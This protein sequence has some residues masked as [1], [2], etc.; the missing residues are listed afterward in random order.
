M[1]RL[2]IIT[3]ITVQKNKSDRYNIFMDYG[4]G[5]EYA[6]SLD[7][8]VLIKSH[9]KKGLELDPFSITEITY[10]DDIRKAYNLAVQY[11]ARRIRSE[12]EVRMYLHKAETDEPIIQEVIH[13]LYEFQFLDDEEYAKAYVRTLMNTTDKGSVSARRELKEK[14][15]SE[16][17]ID[18][19]MRE[20]SS[21]FEFDKAKGISAKFYQ[22]NK[23]DSLRIV[24]QKLEQLLIRKGY[25]LDLIAQV[26]EE[27]K[28]DDEEDSDFQAIQVQGEKAVRKFSKL[29]GYE[30]EQ[31]MKQTLYRKGFSLELVERYLNELISSEE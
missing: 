31:K 5:E 4:K 21:D 18:V 12:H 15:I 29:S 11:L 3:K 6:F 20:Y 22:K 16:A 17:N 24:K 2:A 23:K 19:A 26:L 28:K 7:E 9:L 13:K 14:G 8:D 1:N 27:I 10:Q 30:F 25:G